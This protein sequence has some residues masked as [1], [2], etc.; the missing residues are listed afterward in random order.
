MAYWWVSQNQSYR[1]ERSGGFLWA[2]NHNESGF[3]PFHWDTMNQ[4]RPGDAIFSY[5]SGRIV[6]VSI[7]KT[8]AY[9]SPRPTGLGEGLWE[10]AGKKVDVEYRDLSTPVS[11][12]EIVAELRPLLPERYS[13]LNRFG[14]G[15][16]G[17]LF[18]LPPRARRL[19]LDMIG[20]A[21]RDVIEEGLNQ[22]VRDTTERR[23]L[24]L[25]R[26]GQG[27]FRDSL[28]SVWSGRC[29][30]TGFDLSLLLRAS[31]IKPWRESDNR[32]RL[33]PYNGLLLSP[34][35]DAAFDAGL[36]TFADDGG[37]MVSAEFTPSRIGSL[38][39][40]PAGKIA[41][42]HDKHRGYLQYH[43]VQVFSK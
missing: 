1:P 39:I 18:S 28:M 13:P 35:Y 8:S 42:L 20:M 26:I 23:A 12:A 17:Y 21:Q 15:N 25:S 7:A 14:T 31:H 36:I 19:L 41:G 38:G 43:R 37:V 10:D 33:D 2:P 32:E 22:A 5:V 3:T 16:Q 40:N 4:V 29:A 11:I 30:V 34:T 9:A 6:A 27:Q 24:V